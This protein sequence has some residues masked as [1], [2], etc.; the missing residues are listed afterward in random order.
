LQRN[1]WGVGHIGFVI[2]AGV[3]TGAAVRDLPLVQCE[4]ITL[5]YKAVGRRL[6]GAVLEGQA[7]D[8]NSAP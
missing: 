5:L 2:A 1:L 6:H 4:G 8:D 7:D 3:R